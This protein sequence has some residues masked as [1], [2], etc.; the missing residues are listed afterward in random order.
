MNF[1]RK[2]SHTIKSLP[3][4]ERPR[5]K[6][7]EQGADKLSNAELLAIFLRSGVNGKSALDLA[8]DLLSKFTGLR[9]LLTLSNDDLIKIKGLGQAKVAK[10]KAILEL[11]KRYLEESLKPK[12]CLDSSELVFNFLYHTMRDLDYEIFKVIFLNAQNEVLKI[13]NLFKGSLTKNSV[14]PREV[15]KSALQYKS[16]AMI[17]AHN[18]PSG[19][20]HPSPGDLKTTKQLVRICK[21]MGIEILDHII[22]GDNRYFSFADQKLI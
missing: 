7:L 13:E 19:N 1:K 4:D 15:I 22:V 20:P 16:A 2:S 9:G 8:H 21:I 14:Y 11:S 17:I 10:L 3:A 6:L 12:L 18:H 5:E